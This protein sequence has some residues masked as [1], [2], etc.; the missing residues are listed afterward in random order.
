MENLVMS[1]FKQL[2][3]EQN[4]EEN[5]TTPPPMPDLT[6]LISTVTETLTSQT[7]A[8]TRIQ[9]S[10]KPPM[11]KNTV[12]VSLN[13]L[14]NGVTKRLKMKKQVWC[15]ET[16]RNQWVKTNTDVHVTRGARYGDRIL[17]EGVGDQLRDLQPGDL[18]VTLAPLGDSLS[19]FKWDKK[20]PNDLEMEL[21]V[22]LANIFNYSTELQHFDSKIMLVYTSTDIPLSS[23]HHGHFKV[24][25]LGLPTNESGDN[26]FGDLLLNVKVML[27]NTIEEFASVT[28]AAKPD[29]TLQ[30]KDTYLIL[31]QPDQV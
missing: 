10:T 12:K 26:E 27:P 3:V 1:M 19:E 24:E 29:V 31:A 15:E 23:V 2:Q 18:E 16:K 20:R 22:P 17:I 8:P 5:G 25:G 28:P 30:G 7:Q 13:E 11:L 14:Y 21:E 4:A 9:D 6:K